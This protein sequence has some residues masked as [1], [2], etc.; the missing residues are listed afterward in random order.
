MDLGGTHDSTLDPVHGGQGRQLLQLGPLHRRGLQGRGEAP[1]LDAF[2][3][4]TGV[5]INH[6]EDINGADALNAKLAT[7]FQAGQDTGYDVI[8][9]T[10]D[11]ATK[12][13]RA[14]YL[15]ALEKSLIPNVTA[16][17][18]DSLAHPAGD[19]DRTYTVPWQ[20]GCTGIAYNKAKVTAVTSMTEM[21]TNGSIDACVAWSGDIVQ[22][23]Y[24]VESVTYRRPRQDSSSS[25]TRRSSRPRTPRSCSTR[26]PS[27]ATPPPGSRSP[28]AK[29]CGAC[30]RARGSRGQPSCCTTVQDLG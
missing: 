19:P 7:S 17:L 22:L 28:A 12:W 3:A 4:S 13:L 1:D 25:R 10:E 9:P 20:S 23:Q 18:L 5:R 8:V 24:D 29:S 6:T 11:I 2:A 27:P 21:L 14:G 15:E 30:R 26:R 16:N